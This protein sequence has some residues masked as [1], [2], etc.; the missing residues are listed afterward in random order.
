MNKKNKN[1]RKFS[2]F[3]ASFMLF[4][5]VLNAQ[6]FN[7]IDVSG[8][9]V[10]ANG[11][12]SDGN[13]VV[14]QIGSGTTHSFVWTLADGVTQRDQNRTNNC[15]EGTIIKAVNNTGRLVG[16]TPF[17]DVQAIDDASGNN[18]DFATAGYST[19]GNTTWNML[20]A[21]G[22]FTRRTHYSD[23]PYAISD[24][25]NKIV[26][27]RRL[28]GYGTLVAGYWDVS[29]AANIQYITLGLAQQLQPNG[30]CALAISGNGSMIGGY[31]QT[32]AWGTKYAALWV[33]DSL[34][35]IT[36]NPSGSINGISN[37][38][39]LAAMTQITSIDKAAL[40]KITTNQIIV[41]EALDRE[42]SAFAVSNTGVVVGQWGSLRTYQQQEI[43]DRLAFIY[44]EQ[45]GMLRLD[46]F[47]VRNNISYPDGF[48]FKAVTGISADGSK[49]C[50]FGTLNSKT[51]SFYAEIPPIN[52]IGYLPVANLQVESPAYQSIRLV[53]NAPPVNPA[54]TGYNIYSADTLIQSLSATDTQYTFTALADGTY[55]YTV[56]AVYGTELSDPSNIALITIG[57]VAFPIREEFNFPERVNDPSANSLRNA[58]WD[59]SSNTI[60][61]DAS[62]YV[63]LSGIPP[64]S[65]GF[66]TPQ[67]GEYSEAIS[68]PYMDVPNSDHLFLRFNMVT[69]QGDI[70]PAEQQKLA[71]DLFVNGQW[72]TLVDFPAVGPWMNFIPKSFDISQYAG[73]NDFR[74]RFRCHGTGSGQ[75]LNWFID[76]VE[77]TD[78]AFNYTAPLAIEAHPENNT[79]HV[80]WTDPNG[81]TT[82]RFMRDD[83]AYFSIGNE[84]RPFIAANKY[85]AA[86]ISL[87]GNS[88]LTSLSFYRT[89]NDAVGTLSTPVYK[90]FVM[91]DGVR[92][93]DAPVVNPQIGWNT[94]TLDNPVNIDPSKDLY[95]GVEVVTHDVQD[96]PV[97]C[98]T[99][100]IIDFDVY[101][102]VDLTIFD[103]R[104][105]IFS[106]DNGQTWQTLSSFQ[107]DNIES[108]RNMKYEL[109]CIS[110]TLAPENTTPKERIYGYRL[111]RN[112]ESV[113][114]PIWGSTSLMK[115]NHFTD[116]IPM[117]TDEETCYS[118]YV[119]YEDQEVSEETKTCLNSVSL[120]EVVNTKDNIV[121]LYP[122][123]VNA[124]GVLNVELNLSKEEYNGAIIELFNITNVKVLQQTV[125]SNITPIKVEN[126]AAGVY[127]LR[128]TAK[129]GNFTHTIKIVVSK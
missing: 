60:P 16:I 33:N 88:K 84:G 70:T 56:K 23:Y 99:Y 14:G 104:G 57:K 35:S 90:W 51:V 122:N 79:V 31:R 86:D 20:P 5:M 75:D 18:D 53:W 96:Q 72:I 13:Y 3:T 121:S 80:N 50:G 117:P 43:D 1:V 106:E 98:G 123:P 42:S 115:M 124:N 58:Y 100:Y 34:V 28:T 49:I 97:G 64:N 101:I 48:Y 68:S 107:N 91:Q 59:I 81:C 17:S 108:L 76:N 129:D 110:A 65:A 25:G 19:I 47:F 119:Y 6:T 102:Y 105:N 30:S 63:S 92:L 62:W 73:S 54:L 103:G 41:C 74:V 128:I 109:F 82:L 127:F 27:G 39:T 69:A 52:I 12:S 32:V 15:G 77:I 94:V 2:L 22:T 89:K 83:N 66:L 7:S 113:T 125:T 46:T 116:T 71:V 114:A 95:Y 36:D 37:D 120:S 44:T 118:V 21:S 26:G 10:Y 29:N 8:Q 111:L 93:Y 126:I 87:V 85:P 45:M 55:T 9:D 112:G 38:G 40:Y 4:G 78:V 61:I 11:I 24:D 67:A